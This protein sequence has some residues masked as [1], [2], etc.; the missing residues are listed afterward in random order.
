[1]GV[2]CERCHGPGRE[3]IEAVTRK[4]PP[5]RHIF[6]PGRMRAFPQ[7]QM[8]GA[9][10]GA[11]PADNDF[12]KLRF[13]ETTP[14]TVRFPSQRLVLSRCYN[15]SFEGLKCTECHDPHRNAAAS[16]EE[17]D[18]TCRSCHGEGDREIATI[19]PVSERDCHTCHMPSERVMRHSLFTDHWIRVVRGGGG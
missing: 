9:C 11:P 14:I 6:H 5:G 10:H 8:C 4:E 16:A 7:V 19:C 1:M 15:E 13:I 18:T 3:H 17:H 2:R 12:D